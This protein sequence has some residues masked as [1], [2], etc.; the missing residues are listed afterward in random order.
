[1]LP[2]ASLSI[3]LH[4]DKNLP[5]STRDIISEL[6]C[7]GWILHKYDYVEYLPLGAKNN[8]DWHSFIMKS[9]DEVDQILDA[10]EQAKE[11]IG[12]RIERFDMDIKGDLFCLP[13]SNYSDILFNTYADKPKIQLAP[14]CEIIDLN[15]YFEKLLPPL[16]AAFGVEAFSFTQNY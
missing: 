3:R 8:E 2:S 15:W 10:K 5:I 9:Y 6:T 4:Q 1:M 12:I 16:G 11:L 14:N 7:F 13:E